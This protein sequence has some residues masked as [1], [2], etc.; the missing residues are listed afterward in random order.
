MERFRTNLIKAASTLTRRRHEQSSVIWI[1]SR[2]EPAHLSEFAQPMIADNRQLQ[3]GVAVMVLVP[4]GGIAWGIAALGRLG[5]AEQPLA[6]VALGLGLALGAA[7]GAAYALAERGRRG[8]FFVDDPAEI[9]RNRRL[10][11][12]R[13]SYVGIG[14]VLAATLRFLPLRADYLLGGALCGLMLAWAPIAV[15][16]YVRLRRRLDRQSG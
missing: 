15:A 3:L 1:S 4:L 16:A 12:F 7:A 8:S 2:P 5:A 11:R 10:G 6:V 9:E 14:L 13:W